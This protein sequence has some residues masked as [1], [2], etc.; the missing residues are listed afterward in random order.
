MKSLRFFLA[1]LIG[2]TAINCAST[3]IGA[4]DDARFALDKGNYSTAI[5]KATQAVNADSTNIEA[6][7]ILA[8]AYLGRG[9]LDLFNVA[10]GLVDL[11]NNSDTNFQQIADVLSSTFTEADMRSAV[12]ALEAVPG[13]DSAT[14]TDEGLAD[15]AYLLGLLQAVE[16]F[17]IGVYSSDY[18]G[19]FDVTG[20]TDT[21]RENVQTDLLE[22]DNHL[23]A[24]GVSATESYLQE[25][26]TSW[27][28]LEPLSA[29]DGFT[30]G[31]YRAYVACQLAANPDTVTTTTFSADVANCADINPDNPLNANLSNFDTCITQDTSL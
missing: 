18:Y 7:Y 19:T 17:T 23:I 4:L 14:I 9:G 10:E 15:A 16:H 29:G 25:I 21:D 30:L 6:A 26:R 5:S 13:I 1:V 22:F 20:I 12:E 8:S 24:S 31:E 27:C 28:L 2:L 3:E 11:Q